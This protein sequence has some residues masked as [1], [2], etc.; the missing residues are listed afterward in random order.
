MPAADWLS[1]QFLL[2]V[3]RRGNISTSVDGWS[4]ADIL[5]IATDEMRD[6]IVPM[7]RRLAEEYLVNNYDQ[8]VT[9]GTSDYALPSWAL[10]ESLRDVQLYDGSGGYVSLVRKEPSDVSAVSQTARPT[11]YFL[12]DNKVVLV[13]TP[14]ATQSNGL[15]LRCLRRP[16]KLVE[17]DEAYVITVADVGMGATVAALSGSIAV[18][19]TF[20][21]SYTADI[22]QAGPGF[23]TLYSGLAATSTGS[24][25]SLASAWATTAPLAAVGDYVVLQDRS[26]A[27]QIPNELHAL[28]AQQTV[29]SFL[30]ASGQP[31][32]E[33]A[34][35]KRQV[36]WAE[37]EKLF[38]PR[39]ENQPRYIHNK[40][41]ART[42]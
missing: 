1:D 10:G 7:L 8:T 16:G 20:G 30:R 41:G 5:A 9:S 39:T 2:S 12:R 33:A 29:C 22:I 24:L 28:L 35:A 19:T 32:L 26:P 34:E 36:M 6:S 25:V 18:A 42:G 4:D 37:A 11:C 23:R 21:S 3:K 38:S 15:R 31:G 13:P 14:A 40:Y 27:P 17:L